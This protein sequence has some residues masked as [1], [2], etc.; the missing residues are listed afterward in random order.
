MGDMLGTSVSGLL[1]F[2][3][4]LDTTSH[5]ISN[6]NTEGYSRQRTELATRPAT[7]QGNGFIGNGVDTTSVRRLF[8]QNREDALRNA[9]SDFEASDTKAQFSERIDNLLAD[10]EAGL[11]PQLQSF[12][13]SLQDVANEPSAGSAREVALAE[14]DS[15]VSRFKLLDQRLGDLAGEV[16]NQLEAEVTEINQLASSVADL[17]SEIQQAEGRTSQPANDLRDE[18]DLQIRKLSEK[19]GTQ[20]VEQDNGAKNVFVGNGQPLVSG[21][22]AGELNVTEDTFDPQESVVTFTGASGDPQSVNDTLS[23]GRVGGLLDFRSE[24]LQP[25]RND[26]GRLATEL[27]G[28]VNQQNRLGLDANGDPGE[29]LFATGSPQVF[30]ARDNSGAVSGTPDVAIAEDA[31]GA[32]TGADYE[33]SFDGSEYTVENLDSGAS[34]TIAEN[35]STTFEGLTIDTDPVDDAQAGDR[36]QFQPTRDAVA[37]MEVVARSGNDIAAAGPIRAGEVTGP[38]GGSVNSGSG[39]IEDVTV[40]NDDNVPFNEDVTLQ[41][42][43]GDGGFAVLD[44]DGDAV[45]D[46]SGDDLI[47]PFDPATESG[48]KTFDGDD[49]AGADFSGTNFTDNPLEGVSFTMAGEPDDGDA[50][51]MAE[52]TNAS[53]D[54]RNAQELAGIAD[55]GLLNGG[56]DSPQEFFSGL[57]GEVG[58][59]TRRAQS[60]RDAQEQLRDQAREDRESLSGVNLE[61]EAA[62]LLR[63]QQGFQAAARA[64]S[65]ANEVFQSLLG[66]VQR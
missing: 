53:G 65:V 27:A 41:F 4:S 33:V 57:V 50:F 44:N 36:F 22:R 59:E 66:A 8:D 15:L 48:G 35:G 7:E 26:V 32:L 46:G 51:L 64:T 54:N 23:G 39:T 10:K 5:N 55:E 40:N 31:G 42:R 20:V 62:D 12:F 56:E 2:Q 47:L 34:E 11:S 16:N 45:D 13:D 25:T 24:V 21:D 30:A 58:T 38:N 29:A 60:E 14:A 63:F 37:G 43:E 49:L 19:V 52:N 28:A 1:A 17:N 3:R 18:R 61:E 9:G 6:V